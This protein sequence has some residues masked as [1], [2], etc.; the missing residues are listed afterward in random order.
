MSLFSSPQI[1]C[2]RGTNI[3]Y[4]GGG[5]EHFYTQGGRQ[6]F[7]IG[8]VGKEDVGG[9]EEDVSKANSLVSKASKLSNSCHIKLGM[10]KNRNYLV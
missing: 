8:I 2:P 5:N 10:V 9:E 4:T 6:T 7:S 3:W 1:V